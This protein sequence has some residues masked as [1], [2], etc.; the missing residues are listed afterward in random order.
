MQFRRTILLMAENSQPLSNQPVTVEQKQKDLQDDLSKL[1]QLKPVGAMAVLPTDA[2]FETKDTEEQ[3]IL[4]LRRHLITNLP[5]ILLASIMAI[6]PV[7][8]ITVGFVPVSIEPK[9]RLLLIIIWELFIFGYALEQ[10]LI[11]FFNIYI[12]TNERI[13][14][15]DFHGLLLREIS[16]ADL[17][18]IQDVTIRGAGISA[19]FFHYGD[20]VIQTAAEM[21]MFEFREVPQPETVS[22]VIRELIEYNELYRRR[23]GL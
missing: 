5:W 9:Y 17:D 16:D 12:L 2:S 4:V 6:V 10:F 23:E 14:D 3:V 18:K 13:I 11:W 15:I 20:I 8:A 22:K 21:Q 1:N 7:F 19:A